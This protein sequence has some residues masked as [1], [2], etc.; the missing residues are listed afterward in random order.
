M[1]NA[2]RIVRERGLPVVSVGKATASLWSGSLHNI[3]GGCFSM[4]G[5]H[6]KTSA[7]AGTSRSI[8]SGQRYII[9][10]ERFTGSRWT[11]TSVVETV[12][13]CLGK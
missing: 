3:E 13:P 9:L 2:E 4:S 8:P 11:V 10:T 12:R 5:Y 7:V 6:S 1:T